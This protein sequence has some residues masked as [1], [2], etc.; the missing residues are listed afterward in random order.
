MVWPNDDG[1]Q[2]G[3]FL[4]R[5]TGGVA[6]PMKAM[7]TVTADRASGGVSYAL[8]AER[9][10]FGTSRKTVVTILQDQ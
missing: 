2:S 5:G 8:H 9:K 6:G 3:V 1:G 4:T 10:K 7:V